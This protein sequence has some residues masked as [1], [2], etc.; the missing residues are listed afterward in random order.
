MASRGARAAEIARERVEHDLSRR[1]DRVRIELP[2]APRDS[3]MWIV[4]GTTRKRR[5]D[6]GGGE[7]HHGALASA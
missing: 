3:A 5:L 2:E 1:R 4:N 6:A 7:H